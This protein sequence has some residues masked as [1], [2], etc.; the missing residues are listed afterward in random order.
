M[1]LIITNKSDLA[2]DY[3]ILRLEERGF[4]FFRINTEDFGHDFFIEFFVK[5]NILDGN[6]NSNI[7]GCLSLSNISAVYF[8]QPL[9][10]QIENT[11]IPNQ[12]KFVQRESMEV[13]RSLWRLIPEGKW[14]NDPRNM[15]LASNK[16]DQIKNAIS[17]GF[18]VPNT[19]VSTD[20]EKIKEFI[21]SQNGHCIAK[22]VKHGFYND[23]SK[24]QLAFTKRIGTDFM[25]HIDRYSA[26]PMTYQNEIEKEYDIRVIVIE[27]QVFATAIYSQ[28]Y[29]STAVDW[30]TWDVLE[31]VDLEHA[32]ITLPPNIEKKC[33]QLTKLYQLKYSAID[34]VKSTDGT[35]YFLEL[36]PNGQWAWIEGKV[37]YPIRDSLIN[38]FHFDQ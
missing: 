14:L 36:N 1:L 33:V 25:E 27:D 31:D 23:G 13:L 34:L 15:F 17:I 11:F 26:V 5:D 22:A 8:R 21:L 37:G 7:H 38:A 28:E 29:K 2:V 19:L 35:F 32:K 6:I 24:V 9:V 3:L 18:D 20:S 12:I 16:L 4:I 10:P 30:R